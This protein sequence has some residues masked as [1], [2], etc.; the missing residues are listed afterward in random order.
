MRQDLVKKRMY[1]KPI[2]PRKSGS[3]TRPQADFGAQRMRL[4]AGKIPSAGR[5]GAAY[6]PVKCR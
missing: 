3:V 1:N 6:F 4:E 2:F 5:A